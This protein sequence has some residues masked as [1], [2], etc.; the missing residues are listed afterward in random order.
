MKYTS[1]KQSQ[2]HQQ[3][4]QHKKTHTFKSIKLSLKNN[5]NKINYEDIFSNNNYIA[6]NIVFL[7]KISFDVFFSN[8]Y[9]YPLLIRENLNCLENAN[10]DIFRV[11]NLDNWKNDSSIL[12]KNQYTKVH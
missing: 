7:K 12:L 4:E 8:T 3:E 5:N 11:N 6:K 1:K 10:K 9:K 2:Q